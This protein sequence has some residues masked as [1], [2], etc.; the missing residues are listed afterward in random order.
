MTVVM[1]VQ[2]SV[3]SLSE[4]IKGNTANTYRIRCF[5]AQ[6][7]QTRPFATHL[8]HFR[9]T[10]SPPALHMILLDRGE[11]LMVPINKLYAMTRTEEWLVIEGSM[12]VELVF[13]E[14]FTDD[15]FSPAKTVEISMSRKLMYE[16]LARAKPLEYFHTLFHHHDL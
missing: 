16:D 6:G 1:V 9:P 12:P 10:L 5:S 15:P 13:P 11:I 7:I 4:R 14:S 3:R 2:W 8:A